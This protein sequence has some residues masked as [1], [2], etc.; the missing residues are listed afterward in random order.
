MSWHL[1]WDVLAAVLALVGL[2]TYGLVALRPRPRWLHPVETRHL[3]L[4]GLGIMAL[5]LA[6]G[7]PIHEISEQSLF[8]VHMVQHMLLTLI[9]PPLLLLGTPAWLLRP[10]LTHP[11]VFPAAR[12]LTHPIVAMALFNAALT[13]WHVPD[14][15]EAALQNH[16]LHIV[17]HAIY[18]ATAILLWWPIFSPLSELPPISYPVQ[19]LYL[20]IQSLV[21]AVLAAMITFSE[22]VLYPTYALAPRL[23]DIEPLLDQRIGGLIMKVLGGALLWLLAGIIFF[24]WFNQEEAQAERSWE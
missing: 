8:S 22:Q 2:Y 10:A 19:M 23:W 9:M 24:Q 15:Y 14:L 16:A 6:E 12:L 13:I 1:H 3:F 20:F 4:F 11:R 7:T 18:V 17:N 21:P 5:Y